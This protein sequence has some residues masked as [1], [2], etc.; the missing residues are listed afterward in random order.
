MVSDG[1]CSW[2]DPSSP[3]VSLSDAFCSSA[4]GHHNHGHGGVAEVSEAKGEVDTA[5][6]AGGK[7][8]HSHEQLHA[9][10]GVSLVLGFVFML[11]VDQIGSSHMHSTEGR[12][13]EG[14]Q[15]QRFQ[16]AAVSKL[17]TEAAST[18]CRTLPAG[19][20]DAVVSLSR[21]WRV[22]ISLTACCLFVWF[23]PR[24]SQ[25]GVF[26]N[27]HHSGPGG[28]RGRWVCLS[29]AMFILPSTDLL[30]LQQE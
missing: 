24:V 25:G 12:C 5:L 15:T 16:T 4:G 6:A 7:H 10:I 30:M 2:W 18:R 17:F 26:Q 23:R 13:V 28:P 8:E 20:G 22:R 21:G 1:L 19:L 11:L 29:H 14:Q 27:H 3:C 9:C